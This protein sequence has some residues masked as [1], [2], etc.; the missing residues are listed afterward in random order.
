MNVFAQRPSMVE[1]LVRYLADFGV[2]HA[3]GVSGG[4]IAPLWAAL[5]ASTIAVAC[6][7]HEGGAAFAAI[8]AHFATGE[9]V[10]VFTMTGPGLTNAMMGL[11]AARGD[12]A[13]IIVLSACASAAQRGK[14]PIQQTD[15]DTIPTVVATPGFCLGASMAKTE[16]HIVANR[17][18]DALPN[19]RFAATAPPDRGLF[20]RGPRRFDT[21][22]RTHRSVLCC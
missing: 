3:F 15:G 19:M 6:F 20:L 17:L 7:R 5:S 14:R 8:E 21:R 16:I 11:L 13:K 12:G 10:V 1:A 9:P 18:L 2:R 22:I 4:T